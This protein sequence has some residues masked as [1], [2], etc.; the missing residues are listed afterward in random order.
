M[1]QSRF[2][3]GIQRRWGHLNLSQVVAHELGHIRGGG[4]DCAKSS[5]LGAEQP[6]LTATERQGLLDDAVNIDRY[7]E[8]PTKK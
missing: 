7:L 1:N 3:G 4:F 5:R 2:Q 8:P 6:G